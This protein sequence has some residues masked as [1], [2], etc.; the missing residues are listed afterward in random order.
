MTDVNLQV[1][2]CS[3]FKV[4]VGEQHSGQPNYQSVSPSHSAAGDLHNDTATS[5]PSEE[6]SPLQN[7]FHFVTQQS[8]VGALIVMMVSCGGYMDVILRCVGHPGHDRKVCLCHH[9]QHR[10]VSVPS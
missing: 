2:I 6:R 4:L 3:M 1:I 10:K 7:V 5:K 8:Y 9:D